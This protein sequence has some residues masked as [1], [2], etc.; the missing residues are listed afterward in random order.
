MTNFEQSKIAI[1]VV[2]LHTLYSFQSLEH[3]RL[4]LQSIKQKKYVLEIIF[5]NSVS[6][7]AFVTVL[8]LFL[9]YCNS[10]TAWPTVKLLHD[11]QVFSSNPLMGLKLVVGLR[12]NFP[13]N[14]KKSM[15]LDWF[16]RKSSLCIDLDIYFRLFITK[17]AENSACQND[18]VAAI[19]DF[20]TIGPVVL[21]CVTSKTFRR[22]PLHNKGHFG[23]SQPGPRF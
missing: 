11:L 20:V 21:L 9:S 6:M 15:L 13:K 12:Q 22:N 7:K 1:Y 5:D 14:M 3:K 16:R 2:L 8:L 10:A 19:F 18:Q 23:Q 4:R 17:N